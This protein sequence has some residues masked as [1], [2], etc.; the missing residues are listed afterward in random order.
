[1]FGVI[2]TFIYKVSIEL[3]ELRARVVVEETLSSRIMSDE[4]ELS[5]G[6]PNYPKEPVL[7]LVSSLRFK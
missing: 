4:V 5:K 1:M 3:F 6:R 7:T 2:S